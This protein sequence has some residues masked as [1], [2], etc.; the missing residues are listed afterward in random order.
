MQQISQTA[1][2]LL[3]A[4]QLSLGIVDKKELA[5]FNNNTIDWD[6]FNNLVKFHKVG[7]LIQNKFC[8]SYE[9]YLPENTVSLLKQTARLNAAGI[10]LLSSE[11]IKIS[12]KLHV[13]HIPVLAMKG[14]A[15]SHWLYDSPG[16]RSSGDI[17]LLINSKNW[18]SALTCMKKLG[19]EMS[20]IAD[21]LVPDS[22]FSKQFI[23]AQ[24]DVS[25]K[26][27]HNSTYVELHW[28]FAP[29]NDVF[30]LEFDKAW[31]ARTE[32]DIRG[33]SISQ[34]SDE[35]H[36]VYL[37]YHG[38]R[39]GWDKLFWLYDIA[40]LMLSD[41]TDWN[42]ILEIAKEY[43]A[44]ISLGLALVLASRVFH[45]PVPEIINQQTD[46]LKLGE[47]LSDEIYYKIMTDNPVETGSGMLSMCKGVAW[48]SRINPLETPF[49]SEWLHFLTSPG[50]NDWESIKLP[51][52]LTFL[53]RVMRPFRLIAKGL[54]SSKL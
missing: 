43:K 18:K 10:L 12:H 41:K 8:E 14:L 45:V 13:N 19:Y 9:E 1:N 49:V 36:A 40:L 24:K 3:T 15:I 6:V 52:Y 35:M 50:L 39:H 20:P 29:N 51:D 16:L 31:D 21:R 32:F 27:K 28:R 26:H 37:C 54:F 17:D 46:I 22:R 2:L 34:L 7:A 42:V 44:T 11:L 47:Q 48:R 53:Y 5:E 33:N 25:F 4:L 38:A 23:Q 30:P